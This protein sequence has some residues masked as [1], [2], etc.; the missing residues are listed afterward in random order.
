MTNYAYVG[1]NASWGLDGYD[2]SGQ[3]HELKAK[4]DSAVID[5]T[6]F[7]SRFENTLSGIQ[8][9]S[10][11]VKGFWAPGYKFDQVINQRFGQDPDVNAFYGQNGLSVG[12]T[13]VMQ[14]SVITKFDTDMKT[15]GA[16]E[17]DL[18]MHARGYVD[19]GYV[20]VSPEVFTTTTGTSTG[21]GILDNSLTGGATTAGASAQ[22]HVFAA[23][24]TTPSITG[25]IQHSV[26]GTTYTDVPGLTF[27]ALTAVGSQRL[28][29]PVQQTI[30]PFVKATYT[31]S[32]TTPQF[33][34]L[35]GFARGVVYS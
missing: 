15:K 10:I 16:V 2:F 30:Q 18:A 12:D 24:G 29:T 35:I 13:L 25:K 23:T 26:D 17:F 6:P 11:E 31:I 27:N 5:V 7:G 33:L 21:A 4:R 20:L 3:G 22:I 34:V 1:R 19:D 14:P 9:A 8:K 28:V 32:G